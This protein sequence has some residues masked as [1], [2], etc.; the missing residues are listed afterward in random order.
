MNLKIE[1]VNVFEISVTTYDTRKGHDT[2]YRNI[3]IITDTFISF[4]LLYKRQIKDNEVAIFENAKYA[5]IPTHNKRKL[6]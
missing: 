3:S 4:L 6:M 2:E 1:V 5:T